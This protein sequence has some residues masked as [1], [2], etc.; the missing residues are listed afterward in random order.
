MEKSG[1]WL[2]IDVGSTVQMASGRLSPRHMDGK[3]H[4]IIKKF[5]DDSDIISHRNF[6]LNSA[7]YVVGYNFKAWSTKFCKKDLSGGERNR[8]HFGQIALKLVHVAITR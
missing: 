2:T 5:L 3:Q 7:L 4:G 1:L 8:V 6:E